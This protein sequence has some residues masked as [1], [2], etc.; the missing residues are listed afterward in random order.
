MAIN[1]TYSFG[2]RYKT[3]LRTVRSTAS[4]TKNIRVAPTRSIRAAK[5]R[6][7][8]KHETRSTS[9]TSSN[10]TVSGAGTTQING[11]YVPVDVVNGQTRYVN[12]GSVFT[13]PIIY[14]NGSVW[15]IGAGGFSVYTGGAS[16]ASPFTVAGGNIGSLPAPTV[17]SQTSRQNSYLKLVEVTTPMLASQLRLASVRRGLY[18]Y[19]A[20]MG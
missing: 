16:L 12:G 8:A 6:L 1:K 2:I 10:L 17:A 18:K 5:A 20:A 7:T 11:T 19:A 15:L 3:G 4:I 13:D 9:Q 14:F